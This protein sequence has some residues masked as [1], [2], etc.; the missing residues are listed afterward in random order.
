MYDMTKA[1]EGLSPAFLKDI[2]NRIESVILTKASA[3]F[4]VDGTAYTQNNPTLKRGEMVVN[5][6]DY[7]PCG[8]SLIT[9]AITPVKVAKR[10]GFPTRFVDHSSI[11]SSRTS[12]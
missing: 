4:T 1:K 9:C 7:Q 8:A 11:S 12:V 3:Y 2:Q 6:Y 10:R 5:Y